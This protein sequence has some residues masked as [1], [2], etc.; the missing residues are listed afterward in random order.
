MRLMFLSSEWNVVC[1]TNCD[2]ITNQISWYALMSCQLFSSSDCA[3]FGTD[4]PAFQ[5][6]GWE[7]V[8]LP[9]YALVAR[10]V[11]IFCFMSVLQ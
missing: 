10:V 4:I 11:G 1:T 6:Y 5:M 3:L 7:S 8:L 9:F 2:V